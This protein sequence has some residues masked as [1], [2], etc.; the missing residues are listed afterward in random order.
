MDDRD[1]IEANKLAYELVA[2]QYA[3]EL[4]EEDDPEMRR[5]CRALFANAL[6]GQQ[7]LEIG[8]GPG[9][10]SSFF[11]RAGLNVTA[12]DIS[13]EFLNIV[14]ER[15]PDLVV[16]KMD[17]STPNLPKSSF[18]GLYAFASFIHLPRAKAKST[19]EGF[20]SLLKHPGVLF[21]SLIQSPKLSEYVIE[22]WGGRKDNPLLFTCYRPDEIKKLLG[23][24]GFGKVEVHNIGSQV[25]E[26]LPRLVE[27]EVTHYQI[28]AFT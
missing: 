21:M 14:R 13:D 7:V 6:S 22:D 20:H 24:A 2:R 3:G 25:Y 15:F 12:S 1:Q 28:L 23:G 17:M 26:N 10:D 8:C 27:R 4:P 16:H 11:S 18:D 9:V 19:L 5:A